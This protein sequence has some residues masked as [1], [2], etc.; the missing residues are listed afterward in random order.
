MLLV[1]AMLF[2][3][4][5]SWLLWCINVVAIVLARWMLWCC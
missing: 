5:A 1:V 4:I 2:L 3:G